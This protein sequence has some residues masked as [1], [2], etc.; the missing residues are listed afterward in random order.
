MW[1]FFYLTYVNNEPSPQM[2]YLF[3]IHIEECRY[4]LYIFS[5]ID[6]FLLMAA[7][8]DLLT[9]T[10]FRYAM[11]SSNEF[12]GQPTNQLSSIQLNTLAES[13]IVH[14]CSLLICQ[15]QILAT[16]F[17]FEPIYVLSLL[18]CH[19]HPEGLISPVLGSSRITMSILYFECFQSL[20]IFSPY[21]TSF[22][23]HKADDWIRG[24]MQKG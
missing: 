4:L 11:S 3:S 10:R 2:V 14:E 20:V 12:T 18:F 22:V 23:P 6:L 8:Q 15:T 24:K 19:P 17:P 13:N 5:V 16:C 7:L 21:M 9:I 1:S